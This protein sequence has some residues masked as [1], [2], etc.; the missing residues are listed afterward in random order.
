MQIDI[1]FSAAVDE[2]AAIRDG[3]LLAEERGFDTTWVFDHFA[4]E[5]L[6]GST[7]L[8]CFTLLGALASVTNRIGLG[9]L[10]VNAANR[11]PS[12]MAQSAATVQMISGGRFV[13]GLGAGAAPGSRWSAE[14]EALGI[15]LCA[16]MADRHAV[17]ERTLD[18]LERWWDPNRPGELA[19]FALPIPRPPV[20]V[21]VNSV[22]LAHLAGRRC[23]GINVRGNHDRLGELLA[24]AELGR[25]G[26][27]RLNVPWDCSVWASWDDG[28]LD[29][30]HPDRRRWSALGVTRL[31][32]V[33][34]T[35]A[36]HASI[37]RACPNG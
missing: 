35:R 21:G 10:V 29:A 17:L 8:E 13:L 16:T 31:V 27:G 32:L 33:F 28:L 37:A 7:M 19:T 5:M 23:D 2:W 18:E 4:G 14:H 36:D 34:L 30:D 3:V 26:A 22:G 12:V 11:L 9:S 1:Q 6:G 25:Q 24:A 15:P 20:I